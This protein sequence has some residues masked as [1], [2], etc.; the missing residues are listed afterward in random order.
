VFLRTVQFPAGVLP[1]I[2]LTDDGGLELSWE[3]A[4]G[5]ELQAAF[6]PGGIEIYRAADGKETE[7]DLAHA[8][9]AAKLL[10]SR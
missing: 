10:S 7:L 9:A 8:E 6:L 5:S 3:A 1:S 4:D 2:F